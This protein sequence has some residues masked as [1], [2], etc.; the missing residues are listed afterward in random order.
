LERSL[1]IL[2]PV[3]NAQAALA[4]MVAEVLEVASDLTPSFELVIIDDGS[5]DAT[6]EVADEL[7][8]HFPQVRMIRHHHHLGRHKAV[9]TGIAIS[10]G[11]VV[12]VRNQGRPAFERVHPGSGPA[13][14]NYLDRTR[15]HHSIIAGAEN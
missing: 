15:Q 13:R 6:S 11:D 14:P 5:T 1:S 4:D 2:L 7:T 12:L 8:R 10:R 9:R 3:H